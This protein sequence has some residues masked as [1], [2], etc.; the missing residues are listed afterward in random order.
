MENIKKQPVKEVKHIG[1]NIMDLRLANYSEEEYRQYI[2]S[3]KSVLIFMNNHKN[4]KLTVFCTEEKDLNA[5]NDLIIKLKRESSFNNIN[6]INSTSLKN[7]LSIYEEIDV[8]LGTRMHSN[9]ISFSQSIPF[10]GINWQ[11]KVVGF[12]NNI[13]NKKNLLEMNEFNYN[14]KI[15]VNQ[16]D[17]II[18]NYAFESKKIEEKRKENLSNYEINKIIL[19]RICK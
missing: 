8:L 2:N 14:Y 5:L 9:I 18:S 16:I 6:F 10:V 17:Y 19:K 1:F 13:N 4:Y 15:A 12:F 7:V 11:S 3:F